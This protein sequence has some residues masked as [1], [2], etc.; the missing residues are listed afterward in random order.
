V[1]LRRDMEEIF[2]THPELL[3][4]LEEE[5]NLSIKLIKRV[6]MKLQKS[7]EKRANTKCIDIC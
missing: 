1:N 4:I 6:W 2:E 5:K 3:E 7:T